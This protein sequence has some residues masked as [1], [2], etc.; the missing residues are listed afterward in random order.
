[1]KINR[2]AGRRRLPEDDPT[3]AGLIADLKML[4]QVSPPHEFHPRL[5]DGL[6]RQPPKAAGMIPFPT[7]NRAGAVRTGG[8]RRLL[9]QG[10]AAA[11]FIAVLALAT[12]ALTF[13]VRQATTSHPAIGASGPVSGI[14]K[15]AKIKLTIDSYVQSHI[16]E[17]T[18]TDLIRQYHAVSGTIV[19]ERP[20][21]GAIIAMDSQPRT[22]SRTWQQIAASNAFD[23]FPN[24]ASSVAFTPGQIIQ[25]LLSGIGFDT[26]SF[27]EQTE[28]NN[29]GRLRTDGITI[30]DWCLDACVYGGLETVRDM[31]HYA[32]NIAATL[33]VKLIPSQEFYQYLDSFG[34]GKSQTGLGLPQAN[35]GSLIEPYRMVNAKKVPNPSWRPAYLDLTAF[36]QGV[37]STPPQP[38]Q[39]T[40]GSTQAGMVL[41][42]VITATPLQIADS[43]AAL[44]NGGKLMQPYL[45]KY[46]SL[47]G[48]TTVIQP[49]VLYSVFR[50]AD[51][52]QR[53]TNVLVQS[54]VNGEA[55]EAL[56]PGYDVAAK[57]GTSGMH[58]D[59]I[60][61]KHSIASTVAY[62]PIGETDPARRF[63][64]LIDLKDPSIP[65]GSETAAPAVS[66]IL[67]QL[68]QHYGLKPDPQHTQPT[69]ACHGPDS[70]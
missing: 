13:S 38:G 69:Q 15:G 70:P 17:P 31:L 52:A 9:T 49:K 4:H 1:M 37:P 51:T 43:Y 61:M 59:G 58:S 3:L 44:A 41:R 11:M 10:I 36:G 26:G 66:R 22:D 5:A 6:K 46:Y 21:D 53:V 8:R 34:F 42:R 40:E 24:P 54:D 7:R 14:P 56:V 18:L 48:R 60:I 57:T 47:D 45:V 35:P 28:V 30:Q 50:Q 65:W 39:P 29:A 55:C 23:T 16:V 12:G 19:V 33:L 63:V 62:G 25:P 2:W 27:N 64:V 67:H 68:F 32:S 20:S